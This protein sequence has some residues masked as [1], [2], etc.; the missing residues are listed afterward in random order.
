MPPVVGALVAAGISAGVAY[1]TGAAVMSAFVTTFVLTLASSLLTP[2]PKMPTL[3]NL[4]SAM[5]ERTQM[6]RQP[7]HPRRIIYGTSKVSG[8]LLFIE[9]A[10]NNQDLYLVLALASHEIDGV[11]R[12]Y[13]GDTP[14]IFNDDVHTG[15]RTVTD[16]GSPFN[17]L[18]SVQILKG[19]SSQTLPTAFTSN[20]SL[21]SS[22]QFKGIAVMCA[23]LT[24]NSDAFPNG[25]PSMFALLRGKKVQ[26]LNRN[27]VHYSNNPA[28]IFRDYMTDTKLGVGASTS[29]I[30]DTQLTASGSVCHSWTAHIDD[31]NNTTD[32][33]TVITVNSVNHYLNDGTV[34]TLHDGDELTFGGTAYYVI[35]TDA[36]LRHQP[37]NDAKVSSKHQSFR[38][39]TSQT[40]WRS[41]TESLPSNTSSI[42]AKRTKE[43]KY[44]C[45]GTLLSEATHES[46]LTSIL[47]SCGGNMVFTGGVFR[48]APAVFQNSSLALT[49]D[50]LIGPIELSTKIQ[51]KERFNGVKGKFI[52]PEN[53]WQEADFPTF[54]Q[55]SFVTEDGQQI[56]RDMPMPMTI[57]A[58]Q[59]QR[60]AKTLLFQSRNEIQCQVL[61]NLKGLRLIPNDRVTIT[62]T[63][64]GFSSQLFRVIAVNFGTNNDAIGTALTLKEDTS[65]AYDFDPANDAVVVDPT[66]DTTLPNFRSVS[67]PTI[68]SFS[69]TGDLNNDGTFLSSAIVNFTESTSGFIKHTEI[70]LQANLGGSFV[71]VDTQIVPQGTT[72]TR[73]GGLIVGRV[74]RCLVTCVSVLDVRS[75]SATSS[76]LT[77]TADT[78]APSAYSGLT[79]TGIG[80]GV[81]LE[82]TNPSEDDFRGAEFVMRT[83]TGNP[84]SGGNATINFSIAGSPSQVMKTARQNLTAGTQQ[85]FWIRSID[86]SGNA[87]AFFPD[88][89]NGITATPQAGG[90][91]V[92]V[93]GSSVVSSGVANL[94]SFASIDQITSANHATLIGSEAIGST[95]IAD[96]AI[97]TDKINAGAVNAGKI[98]VTNLSS[99]SATI[100]TLQSAS[101]GARLV[102]QTDKVQVFDSSGTERVRLGNL[103]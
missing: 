50:D 24:F 55:S 34:V 18:I 52:S 64:L 97:T 85:R 84:N 48:L 78:T 63:R 67:T 89:A 29:E 23:K 25:I 72:Q 19:T 88:N 38:L 71:T 73:F 56:F 87:S 32:E 61:V 57:S 98:S 3:G 102:V 91:D 1:L 40:N 54:T 35:I 65:N 6:V 103:S 79:A 49:D 10:N 94:G 9:T 53:N 13:A 31:S 4:N 39:A 5:Q 66:P 45:D 17:N 41:R 96:G 70:N 20:T 30:D 8:T 16:S 60:I 95:V 69:N 15:F 77:V 12:I 81:L 2:K 68:N 51:R 58:M 37:S 33:F 75:T 80:E 26:D 62:S 86:M 59:A 76:N 74:Y 99:V 90:V 93:N 11:M 42:T 43:I 21:T 27:G 28:Y 44:G 101:S 83:S 14:I 100:G 82:F 36:L 47:S 7:A 92:Q 46:N 22:D